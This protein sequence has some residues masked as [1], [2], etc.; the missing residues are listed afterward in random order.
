[1]YTAWLE[2]FLSEVGDAT[3]TR[4]KLVSS[5][6]ATEQPASLLDFTAAPASVSPPTR[7][8]SEGSITAIVVSHS[9]RLHVA[10]TNMP[11]EPLPL[12]ATTSLSTTIHPG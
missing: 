7:R 8:Q 5:P 10:L 11:A 1:M 4:R 2:C 3:K 9:S 12:A 6:E